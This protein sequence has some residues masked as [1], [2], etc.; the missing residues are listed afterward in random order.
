MKRKKGR[1]ILKGR[2]RGIRN[3][4]E[5]TTTTTA[6]TGTV[7]GTKEEECNGHGDVAKDEYFGSE[8]KAE[9]AA[10]TEVTKRF[11]SD[12]DNNAQNGKEEI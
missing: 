12:C 8:I 1:T 10:V 9:E 2:W 6:S 3:E 11:R 5:S 7:M 4:E